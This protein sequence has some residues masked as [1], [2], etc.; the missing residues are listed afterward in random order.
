MPAPVAW[1]VLGAAA[2]LSVAGLV[3]ERAQEAAVSPSAAVDTAVQ[4][5]RDG[6][7][8][9]DG[10]VVVPPWEERAWLGLQG[11]GPGTERAPWPALLRHQRPD[12]VDLL[13]FER[14]WVLGVNGRA[15]ELAGVLPEDIEGVS[16]EAVGQG[17]TVATYDLAPMRVLARLSEDLRGATFTRGEKKTRGRLDTRDVFHADR[18]W[19]VA[20]PGP[21]ETPL[22][23]HWPERPAGQ[24]IV[25]VGPGHMAVRRAGGSVS[26]V[27]VRIGGERSALLSVEPHTYA[28]Y[29]HVAPIEEGQDVTLILSA[30]DPRHR[31]NLLE[32]EVV[33]RLPASVL[34][35]IP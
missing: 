26:E 30:S 25:R 2:A 31:S 23:I 27:E 32:V 20:D 28:L 17:A 35:G 15:A 6:F 22:R 34:A 10:V 33:D 21:P 5:V 19:V 24:L 16:E 11:I 4:R 7:Q 13:R 18:T 8:A 9:G 14:I 12:P 1:A 3:L 29:R